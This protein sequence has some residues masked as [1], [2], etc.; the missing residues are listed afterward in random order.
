MCDVRG[1]KSG[2][3][4]F[5]VRLSRYLLDFKVVRVSDE[6]LMLYTAMCFFLFSKVL[7]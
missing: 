1:K 7:I 6:A 3:S 2:S 4:H 5:L